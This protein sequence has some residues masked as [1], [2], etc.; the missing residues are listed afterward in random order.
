MQFTIMETINNEELNLMIQN[1]LNSENTIKFREYKDKLSQLFEEKD[2]FYKVKI[3][4][5]Q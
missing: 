4:D 3:E 1:L 5:K 2:T